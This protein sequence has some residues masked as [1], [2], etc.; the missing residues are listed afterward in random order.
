MRAT[1][2]FLAVIPLLALS[3]IFSPTRA[4]ADPP[5]CEVAAEWAVG[6]G[7]AL[8]TT[9]QELEEL[10]LPYRKAVYELSS[11]EVRERWWTE[12][13]GRVLANEVL[14]TA[15][16]RVIQRVQADLGRLLVVVPASAA[17]REL[18]QEIK[19]SFDPEAAKRIFSTLGVTSAVAASSS[20]EEECECN[21]YMDYCW[22]INIDCEGGGEC[23]ESQSGCG[24]LWQF[25]CNGTCEL[26]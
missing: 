22:G 19:N 24:T 7:E 12:H 23:E 11:V 9:L 18:T 1:F 3:A 13:L 2:G 5:I 20:G 15:Q 4:V 17:M 21:A 25:A 16:R 6:L 8:P 26:L 14:T 10:D